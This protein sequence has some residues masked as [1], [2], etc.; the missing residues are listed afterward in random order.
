MD[1]RK[2]SCPTRTNLL[3]AWQNASQ[4]YGQ[5]I[6]DLTR[7]IGTVSKDEYQ[8]LAQAAE[9]ARKNALAAQAELEAHTLDRGCD[10]GEFAA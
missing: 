9:D 4:L 8:K 2:E 5:A 3:L 10:G 7:K 6:A 1:A